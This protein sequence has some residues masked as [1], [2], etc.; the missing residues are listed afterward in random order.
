MSKRYWRFM[1]LMLFLLI[2]MFLWRGL[3]LDPQNLPSVQL[4]KPL[5]IFQ[6][7]ALGDKTGQLTPQLMRGRVALL[8]IWA[9]WCD[10][11]TQEQ[12]FLSE[13]ADEGVVI[14]GINY[15]DSV[16]N[17]SQWL[18]QWGNPYQLIGRDTNGQV[19]ID[20]G[21]YG[22]PET[23]LIDAEGSIQYRHA[24]PLTPTVWL[25]EFLPRIKQLEHQQ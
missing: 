1:P 18:S 19:A 17:A 10:A 12:S 21:V 4:G 5:P 22:A 16:E 14:Y 13:L 25:H 6:L 11:C 23:F 3:S 2:A 20:L 15:K 9:S 24:G 8:N 7:D